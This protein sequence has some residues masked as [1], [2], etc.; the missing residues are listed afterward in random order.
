MG[1]EVD[2]RTAGDREGAGADGDM[3]GGDADQIDEQRHREDGAAA[4]DAAAT[5]VA[6]R[7]DVASPAVVRRPANEL[8]DDTDLGERLV[9]VAV[10]E[11][12]Q[13][14]VERALAAGAAFAD[15]LRQEGL[16]AAA[17]LSLQGR[18]RVVR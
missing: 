9:T 11:L 6:N 12:S 7:V 16:I 10:G 5:Q 2:E 17:A 1:D 8:K 14:E 18:S 13:P 15:Q 4:A 3:G